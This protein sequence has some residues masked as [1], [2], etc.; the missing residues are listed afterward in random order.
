MNNN[1][2]STPLGA[3]APLGEW[4]DT[5]IVFTGN[6]K[7]S[8]PLNWPLPTSPSYGFTSPTPRLNRTP[9]HGFGSTAIGEGRLSMGTQF[10]FGA[11][12]ELVLYSAGG[13]AIPPSSKKR[14]GMSSVDL[15]ALDDKTNVHGS[16]KGTRTQLE[17][18]P[19]DPGS[20]HVGGAGARY[21]TQAVPRLSCGGVVVGTDVTKQDVARQLACA[22]F[23]HIGEKLTD[24]GRCRNKSVAFGGGEGA[25]VDAL[26]LDV[27]HNVGKVPLSPLDLE[28]PMDA[29]TAA[30]HQ[31]AQTR[32]AR[33]E[34]EDDM[35]ATP[36]MRTR[37]IKCLYGEL[38]S[39]QE[40]LSYLQGQIY[41][42]DQHIAKLVRTN[43]GLW[44]CSA[45]IASCIGMAL[46]EEEMKRAAKATEARG[47]T[48]VRGATE[49]TEAR[50]A[51]NAAEASIAAEPSEAR[52]TKRRR[53][54]LGV[55]SLTQS[56]N[57][58]ANAEAEAANNAAAQAAQETRT[59]MENTEVPALPSIAM[60]EGKQL[61]ELEEIFARPNRSE[62]ATG[63]VMNHLL[64]MPNALKSTGMCPVENLGGPIDATLSTVSLSSVP[65]GDFNALQDDLGVGGGNKLVT[66]SH[67]LPPPVVLS[68][69]NSFS[70]N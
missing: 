39:R 40:L 45:H 3:K 48:E 25:G 43:C 65:L 6:I 44:A 49:A 15:V 24:G 47:A 66:N 34:E 10:E 59:E 62:F 17:I 5:Q 70:F 8:S 68:K 37:R 30:R 28:L 46:E 38:Q 36:E 13:R 19:L 55:A 60:V 54:S 58:K 56:L 52:E 1:E 42:A 11:D 31:N 32:P 16:A 53:T 33:V 21:G 22:N 12:G 63:E 14:L 41:M 2:P 35:T 7:V 23:A 20:S 57:A 27:Q 64:P 29:L 67:D 61:E 69:E 9:V 50:E 51:T 4:R 18:T 26:E